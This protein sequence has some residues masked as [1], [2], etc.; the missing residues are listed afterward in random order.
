MKKYSTLLICLLIIL[1]AVLSA[2]TY[3]DRVK[4]YIKQYYPLALKNK[5]NFNIPASITLAQGIIESSAGKG[6]LA[7]SANNHFGIKCK[8]NWL[9]QVFYKEDDDVDSTGTLIRSCFRKYDSVEESFNDHSEFLM[10]NPRYAPLFELQ[11]DDYLGWATGLKNCGYATACTYTKSLVDII[12]RWNLF[13]FDR[14]DLDK[15]VNPYFVYQTFNFVETRK[16]ELV[17]DAKPVAIKLPEYYH[18]LYPILA[19]QQAK[20]LED[21]TEASW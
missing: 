1:P 2:Q 6:M 17:T 7:D 14:L 8:D 3:Q 9:G 21:P 10:T 4:E 16:K 5:Q 18:G 11:S 13:V 19:K 15:T 20:D 12:E